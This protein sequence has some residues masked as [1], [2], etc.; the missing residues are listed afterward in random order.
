MM[1]DDVQELLNLPN[2]INTEHMIMQ[3]QHAS[4]MQHQSS[5]I[6]ADLGMYS[7]NRRED[8]GFSKQV[9]L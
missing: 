6:S 9:I 8:T 1:M 2:S 3:F 4:G 7:R 5:I